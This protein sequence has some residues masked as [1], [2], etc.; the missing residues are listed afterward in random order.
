MN[1]KK[2][3]LGII[4]AGGFAETHMQYFSEIEDVEIVAASRKNKEKHR[5]A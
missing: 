1:L 3:R 2:V 5:I 4:G